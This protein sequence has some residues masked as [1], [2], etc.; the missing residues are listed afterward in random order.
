MANI[1]GNRLAHFIG[2]ATMVIAFLIF[3]AFV[4]VF[5]NLNHWAEQWGSSLNMSVYF[6][7]EPDQSELGKVKREIRDFP[8]V[9]VER[10]VSKSQALKDL[11]GRLGSKAEL[12][13]GIENN[14]LPA[15]LEITFSEKKPR[16]S[17]PLKLKTGLEKLEII[18]EVQY[19]QE[20]IDR[21]FSL[22]EAIKITGIVFGGLILLAALFII[23]NT[24]KLTIYSR[25]DEIAILKLVGAT[26][27]FIRIP[28]LLEGCIQG[29]LGGAFALI[30][31]FCIYFIFAKMIDISIGFVSLDIIFIPPRFALYLLAVSIIVGV[32]GSS[33]SLRRLS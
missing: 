5:F 27:R 23:A 28:F 16:E 33:V 6:V 20:W 26:N 10:Y 18:E 4:L 17:T 32:V 21:F 29:F 8:G 19:S 13:E 1:R 22:L 9:A 24:I 31:L 3:F 30:I 11:K 14:P 25:R 2:V 7:R 12:L 15:S